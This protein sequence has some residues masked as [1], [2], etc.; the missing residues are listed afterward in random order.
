MDY[1]EKNNTKKKRSKDRRTKK[2]KE[3]ARWF[4]AN[5]RT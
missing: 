3:I 2:F 1:A 4:Y 5:I